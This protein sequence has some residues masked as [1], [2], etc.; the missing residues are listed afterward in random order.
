MTETWSC[1][2]SEALV[3]VWLPLLVYL[4]SPKALANDSC[5]E[6]VA[7]LDPFGITG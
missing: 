5:K 1:M 4:V 2:G 7:L 3:E 6:S